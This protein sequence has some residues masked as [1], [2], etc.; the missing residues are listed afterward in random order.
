MCSKNSSLTDCQQCQRDISSN[1]KK[2]GQLKPFHALICRI[3]RHI[4][5]VDLPTVIGKMIVIYGEGMTGLQVFP[6]YD[7]ASS[8][9]QGTGNFD[10]GTTGSNDRGTIT[11]PDTFQSDSSDVDE[12]G[13]T[14]PGVYRAKSGGRHYVDSS[15]YPD[16]YGPM[17]MDTTTGTSVKYDASSMDDR[18]VSMYSL[19]FP[20]RNWIASTGWTKKML[21][22]LRK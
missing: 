7:L 2:K 5:V 4:T 11:D 3:G 1:P 14:G 12:G 10:A 13:R 17:V 9:G 18:V 19:E 8:M 20:F 16:T 6:I 15:E 22:F 21:H